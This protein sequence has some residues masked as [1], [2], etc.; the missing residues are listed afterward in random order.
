[1]DARVDAARSVIAGLDRAATRPAASL[2]DARD[3]RSVRS[4]CPLSSRQ[5]L[6]SKRGTVLGGGSQRKTLLARRMGC[7]AHERA[8]AR[9]PPP[10]PGGP[11]QRAGLRHRRR[12]EDDRQC[13]DGPCRIGTGVVSSRTAREISQLARLLAKPLRTNEGVEDGAISPQ[14]TGMG[15]VSRHPARCSS[16]NRAA[17]TCY[18]S[19]ATVAQSKPPFP[20]HPDSTSAGLTLSH[21]EPTRPI[22][23]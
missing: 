20:R 21:K 16:R 2:K 6:T 1:M 3:L 23:T 5:G 13:H 12:V 19:V 15:S 14:R 4:R 10:A 18:P 8:G 11:S 17:S 22:A 7:R 9:P